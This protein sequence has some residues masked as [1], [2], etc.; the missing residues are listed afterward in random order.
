[1]ELK[2]DNVE[3]IENPDK[4]VMEYRQYVRE[5]RKNIHRRRRK[6]R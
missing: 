4:I 3:H 5:V 1:M 2:D 6:Y